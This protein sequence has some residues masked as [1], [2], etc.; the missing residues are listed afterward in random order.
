MTASNDMKMVLL[1]PTANRYV[2]MADNKDQQR[3]ICFMSGKSARET[4]RWSW[5]NHIIQ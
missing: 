2:A 1:T 4:L 5:T 3:L